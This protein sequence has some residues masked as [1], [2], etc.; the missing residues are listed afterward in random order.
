MG[1]PGQVGPF[2]QHLDQQWAER[3]ACEGR[4]AS[5]TAENHEWTSCPKQASYLTYRA[6]GFPGFRDHLQL[7][8]A[9][10]TDSH[11]TCEMTE[12]R[13]WRS[14][15][16]LVRSLFVLSSTGIE[17]KRPRGNRFQLYLRPNRHL[18]SAY[19]KVRRQSSPPSARQTKMLGSGMPLKVL[20][21]QVV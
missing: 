8:P 5:Q 4:I 18:K 1:S 20:F 9:S 11:D 10:T 14:I 17:Q 7:S 12:D 21:L 2:Q 19:P 6:N 3:G 15:A 16:C 13:T